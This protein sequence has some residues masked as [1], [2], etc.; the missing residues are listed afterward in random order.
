MQEACLRPATFAA[1]LQA[2]AVALRYGRESHSGV[3]FEHGSHRWRCE[4]TQARSFFPQP[5]P[6]VLQTAPASLQ[7]A[8][9]ARQSALHQAP[10]P[11]G[12]RLRSLPAALQRRLIHASMPASGRLE[13][14]F[15]FHVRQHPVGPFRKPLFSP[16][17]PAEVPKRFPER[18]HTLRSWPQRFR[19]VP[20]PWR[21]VRP[22]DSKRYPVR[23][24]VVQ[25]SLPHWRFLAPVNLFR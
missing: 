16:R 6:S 14:P 9:K 3:P 20:A 8:P 2:P 25:C 10:V 4:T 21:R 23:C 12:A 13:L 18:P 19:A 11:S 17:I 7:S 1:A 15:A 24:G 22:T 5:L